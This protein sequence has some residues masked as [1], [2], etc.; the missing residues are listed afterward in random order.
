M[1][2]RS[3]RFWNNPW[4]VS[5]GSALVV[6]LV[7]LLIDF[8]TKEV[9]FSTL[10]NCFIFL[11]NVI[12]SFLNTDVKIWLIMLISIVLVILFCLGRKW[13]EI[14]TVAITTPAF[15]SYTTDD[16]LQFKW[17]WHWEK[18][19][20]GKYDIEDLHPVCSKCETPLVEGKNYCE[21][22]YI[23]LRCNQEFYRSLPE[24]DNVKMLILDNVR[25]KYFPNE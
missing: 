16:I 19:Y 23:C 1:S 9:V 10:K 15:L 7:S 11:R 4:T 3:K 8:I 2:K 12:S 13:K 18:N 6:L 14:K 22:C 21:E 5:I 17:K 25:R 24:Y 20:D